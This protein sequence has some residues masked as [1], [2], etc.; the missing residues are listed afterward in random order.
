LVLLFVVD[1]EGD[2]AFVLLQI[3]EVMAGHFHVPSHP[4]VLN[5]GED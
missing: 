2:L 5:K 4:G 3:Q 1:D